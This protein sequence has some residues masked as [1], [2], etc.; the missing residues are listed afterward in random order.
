M[1]PIDRSIDNR[2][3]LVSP[4]DRLH[5][6][7]TTDNPQSEPFSANAGGV[8]SHGGCTPSVAR[9]LLLLECG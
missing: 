3:R 9:P 8:G 2:A 7:H 6:P 1:S 4:S 5:P